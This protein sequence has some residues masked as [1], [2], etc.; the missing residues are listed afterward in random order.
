MFGQPQGGFGGFGANTGGGLFGGLAQFVRDEVCQVRADTACSHNVVDMSHTRSSPMITRTKAQT[1][2][3]A[4]SAKILAVA[5]SGRTVEEEC[6]GSRT[7]AAACLVALPQEERAPLAARILVEGYLVSQT[8]EGYLATPAVALALASRREVV[9]SGSKAVG[10]A[11]LASPLLEVASLAAAALG[12]LPAEACLASQ[13]SRKQ[14]GCSDRVLVAAC[15]D[16]RTLAAGYLD[17]PPKVACLEE[18]EGLEVQFLARPPR[19]KRSSTRKR[20]S[21]MPI[22]VSWTAIKT[23]PSRSRIL[24][25]T[26]SSSEALCIR[27][28]HRT[29]Q[30]A[31]A[32]SRLRMEDY[33]AN[34]LQAGQGSR[35]EGSNLGLQSRLSAVAMSGCC[36]VTE[37]D[38]NYGSFAQR[39]EYLDRNCSAAQQHRI[40]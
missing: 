37:Q 20:S 2:V 17:S 15:L 24:R 13:V 40:L 10:A 34:R 27:S 22:S 9:C 7:L 35:A 30:R 1:L 12:S 32:D 21:S 3:V 11:F 5:F 31:V 6:S 4:C 25:V 8:L 33:Q 38:L 18:E 16:N 29:C 39:L 19:C 26:I 14:E 23:N 36:T 28:P